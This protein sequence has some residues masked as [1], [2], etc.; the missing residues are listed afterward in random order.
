MHFVIHTV[1]VIATTF[2]VIIMSFITIFADRVN[3][4]GYI[5]SI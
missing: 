4:P 3:A 1:W 5:I 2:V